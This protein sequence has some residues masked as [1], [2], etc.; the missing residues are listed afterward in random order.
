MKKLCLYSSQ[1]SRTKVFVIEE[2]NCDEY[3]NVKIVS[4]SQVSE[5]KSM[6]AQPEFLTGSCTVQCAHE[7]WVTNV[8]NANHGLWIQNEDTPD[9]C[10]LWRSWTVTDAPQATL[11]KPL[12][13]TQSAPSV[14]FNLRAADN[15]P[16]SCLN[17]AH[18]HQLNQICIIAT[19]I[20]I[21]WC[22]WPP[23][24]PFQSDKLCTIVNNQIS[25]PKVTKLPP[26]C[27]L[28]CC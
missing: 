28:W 24:S 21:Q 27:T 4:E 16:T 8:Q 6:N 18:F 12:P 22:H 14:A 1:I 25:K 26:F 15:Q 9:L 20:I 7:L 19:D 17:K 3:L 10:S 13:K 11:L 5:C 23:P 2:L